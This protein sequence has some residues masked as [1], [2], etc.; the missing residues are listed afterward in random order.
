MTRMTFFTM[1]AVAMLCTACERHPASELADEHGGP[2]AT[3]HGEVQRNPA[4]SGP[5]NPE[6]KDGVTTGQK[7]E[8]KVEAPATPAPKGSSF[9][10]SNK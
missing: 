2:A 4:G 8:P 7:L 1:A 5:V 3:V 10:P 6:V 9:F